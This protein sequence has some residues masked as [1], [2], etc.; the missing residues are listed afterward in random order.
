[1]EVGAKKPSQNGKTHAKARP[2]G[3]ASKPP[4]RGF[5]IAVCRRREQI[6]KEVEGFGE[7]FPPPPPLRV[8]RWG[9][10]RGLSAP[11]QTPEPRPR[12]TPSPWDLLPPP[13]CHLLLTQRRP[14]WARRPMGPGSP[15]SSRRGRRGRRRRRRRW[16]TSTSPAPCHSRRSSARPSVCALTPPF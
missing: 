3:L 12:V 5:R 11:T 6:G 15:G 10:R 14:R 13:P 2:G 1:M 4:A 9:T 8:A 7:K 16:T